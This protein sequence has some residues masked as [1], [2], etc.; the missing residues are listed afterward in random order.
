MIFAMLLLHNLLSASGICS[1]LDAISQSITYRFCGTSAGVESVSCW[2]V[3][4]TPLHFCLYG[5]DAASCT[6]TP[7]L[8]KCVV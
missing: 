5:V 8:G 6:L 1:P 7:E 4:I 2:E 3:T